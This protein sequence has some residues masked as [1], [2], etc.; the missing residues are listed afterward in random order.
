MFEVVAGHEEGYLLS[1]AT[2]RFALDRIRSN[3]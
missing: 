1:H 3:E 2:V